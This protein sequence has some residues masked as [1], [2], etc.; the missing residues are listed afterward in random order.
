MIESKDNFVFRD[1]PLESCHVR[2]IQ[3]RGQRIKNKTMYRSMFRFDHRRA[4]TR[5][6]EN[7]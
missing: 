1:A 2:Y 5:L 6:H 7:K 3:L 4:H